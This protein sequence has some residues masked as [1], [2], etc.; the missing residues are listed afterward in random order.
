MWGLAILAIFSLSHSRQSE[1]VHYI[2]AAAFFFGMEALGGLIF[3]VQSELA[4][5]WPEECERRACLS[6][7]SPRFKRARVLLCMIGIAQVFFDWGGLTIA[8]FFVVVYGDHRPADF[9][10]AYSGAVTQWTII[11]LISLIALNFSEDL[12][13]WPNE[14]AIAKH[15]GSIKNRIDA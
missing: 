5:R 1:I 8:L 2:G 11:S 13:V 14:M 9:V 7:D 3:F 15:V 10:F 4:S 6:V 12:R